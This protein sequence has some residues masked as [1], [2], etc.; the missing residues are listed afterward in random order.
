MTASRY[1][2]PFLALVFL[3]GVPALAQGNEKQPP[4]GK[5]ESPAEPEE[6]K[7]NVDQ[8]LRDLYSFDSPRRT[9]AIEQLAVLDNLVV[10]DAL[11]RIATSATPHPFAR[12]SA[13]AAL[14]KRGDP[15]AVPH[16]NT[17]LKNPA[18]RPDLRN[19]SADALGNIG[20]EEAEKALE[21]A[22]VCKESGSSLPRLFALNALYKYSRDKGNALALKIFRD[23]GEDISLRAGAAR[24]LGQSAGEENVGALI[25]I[26]RDE[27]TDLVLRIAC[28]GALSATEAG[29]KNLQPVMADRAMPPELRVEIARLLL[30]HGTEAAVAGLLDVAADERAQDSVRQ[31]ALR[32]LTGSVSGENA[33]ALIKIAEGEQKTSPLR[34]QAVRLLSGL[35]ADGVAKFFAKILTDAA[36]SGPAREIAAKTLGRF[37]DKAGESALLE[38]LKS[39]TQ[40]TVRAACAQ[41]LARRGSA[42]AVDILGKEIET[43]ERAY[44]RPAFLKA[45]AELSPERARPALE[46]IIADKKEEPP[47]RIK[48]LILLQGITEGKVPAAAGGLLAARDDDIGV[49]AQVIDFIVLVGDRS[50]ADR[51]YELIEDK[52]ENPQL[53]ARCVEA[54]AR[55]S[56]EG[57]EEKLLVLLG[58]A[59]AIQSLREAAVRGL[60][61][62]KA[63][64]AIPQLLGVF[65]NDR[66]SDLLRA[67]AAEAL[68]EIGD[69][70]A[71]NKVREVAENSP[72]VAVRKSAVRLL[73]VLPDASSFEVLNKI[74][75]DQAADMQVRFEAV[76]S[77]GLLKDKRAYD[78]LAAIL[79][80]GVRSLMI[81]SVAI[82]A[83]GDLG[84]E[85]ALEPLGRIVLLP[86]M[87]SFL[88]FPAVNAIARIGGDK[89]IE[90]LETVASD[91]FRP[92]LASYARSRLEELRKQKENDGRPPTDD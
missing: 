68:A 15:K 86:T 11:I 23:A 3:G 81:Q 71:L 58:K 19:Y 35:D 56:L 41:A 12:G 90:I 55:M 83:L 31:N 92:S 65:A 13:I 52:E 85:R 44:L 77:L 87:Q 38:T 2:L 67:Q 34:D 30:S 29:R 1:I 76:R 89:A 88:Q 46:K 43:A 45:L 21:E 39:R 54:A 32:L 22:A 91:E 37:E 8:L 51:I 49:R 18:E 57:A 26:A 28:A 59:D 24:I 74:S 20:G 9:R 25:K 36:E 27:K 10:T 5:D 33:G 42:A 50:Y 66:E 69:K 4:P 61:L 80:E 64:G 7:A 79:G 53:R 17:I 14:G 48:A 16:L 73:G 78:T 40:A 47:H 60:G 70:S 82:R 6:D 62:M 72:S 84:D 63:K 75:A